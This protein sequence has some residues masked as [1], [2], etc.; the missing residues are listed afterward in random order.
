MRFFWLS[1]LTVFCFVVLG[2]GGGGDPVPIH[3]GTDQ[4]E[5]CKMNIMDNRFGSETVTA[6]NKVY[7]FDSIE[8]MA[9]YN[10][11]LV[12]SSEQVASLWVTDFYKPESF[13]TLP[14]AQI[15]RTKGIR[16]P[17]G[18][19]FAAMS[20]KQDAER[21]RSEYGGELLNWSEVSKV[22]ADAWS[23]GH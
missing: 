2:C 20:S 14:S 21:F 16:S 17:M 11:K 1:I 3:Y 10:A 4:C 5:N 15:I 18:L 22:V 13:I 12:Q 8:C 6:T 9:A 7:K 23:S 19:G